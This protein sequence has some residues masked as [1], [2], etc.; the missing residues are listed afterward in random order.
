MTPTKRPNTVIVYR[1]VITK[2]LV[3]ALGGIP[4]QT[5]RPGNL[6]RYYADQTAA[7]LSAATL[8]VHHTVIGAA[9]KSALR[10]GLVTRNVATLVDGRPRA[11]ALPAGRCPQPVLQFGRHSDTDKLKSA[12]LHLVPLRHVAYKRK[13]PERDHVRVPSGSF[14]DRQAPPL[15]RAGRVHYNSATQ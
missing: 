2:H 14:V 13:K 12:R 6:T 3:P 10:A 7:G 4:L 15:V 11:K 9:L 8:Q 5:L 1:N